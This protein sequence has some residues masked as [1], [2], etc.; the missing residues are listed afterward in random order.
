MPPTSQSI[1][2]DNFYAEEFSKQ[3][4]PEHILIKFR[5]LQPNSFLSCYGK[6]WK[7]N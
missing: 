3:I 1:P 2:G 6:G 5:G 4:K 7:G